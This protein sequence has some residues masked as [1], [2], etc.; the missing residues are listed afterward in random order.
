MV[1]LVLLRSLMVQEL[2]AVP[3]NLV[4]RDVVVLHIPQELV[5]LALD[6]RILVEERL[7]VLVFVVVGVAAEVEAWEVLV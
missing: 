5:E 1:P 4:E 7:G 3:Q 6:H 2:E